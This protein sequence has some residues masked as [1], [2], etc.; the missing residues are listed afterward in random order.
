MNYSPSPDGKRVLVHASVAGEAPDAH[1]HVALNFFD[2][3][4]R[5]TRSVV[6]K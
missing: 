6:T 2:E 4:R 5:R 1:V 3:I